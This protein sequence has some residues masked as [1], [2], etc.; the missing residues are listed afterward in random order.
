MAKGSALKGALAAM[1]K[2]LQRMSPG[3]YRNPQGQLVGSQ[4]QR[5]PNQQPQRPSMNVPQPDK[6]PMGPG[7]QMP[8]IAAGFGS[9]IGAAFGSKPYPQQPGMVYAGGNPNFNEMSGQYNPNLAAITQA[10]MAAQQQFGQMPQG[11]QQYQPPMQDLMYRYPAGTQ[12]PD[13]G[14]VN[15]LPQ[16]PQQ[17]QP[18]QPQSVSG[19]L[20]R[21]R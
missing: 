8:G 17:A 3:V 11:Q 5:L 20:Q 14:Q 2:G 9:G 4:G 10:S 12:V 21:F 15:G 7:N 13:L 6:M 19:L 16:Q 18:Q 1:P